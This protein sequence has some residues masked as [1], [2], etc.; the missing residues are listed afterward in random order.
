M[1]QFY[2]C[3]I[4]NIILFCEI[5]LQYY[6]NVLCIFIHVLLITKLSFCFHCSAG[7]WKTVLQNCMYQ[8]FLSVQQ[9][10]LVDM[11]SLFTLCYSMFCPFIYFYYKTFPL[12]KIC[13]MSQILGLVDGVMT[14]YVWWISNGLF[15]AAQLARS[16]L[17]YYPK[18]TVH[19]S[20]AFFKQFPYL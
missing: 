18:S 20:V 5:L 11:A 15:N 16:F 6:T 13:T 8:T 17:L 7:V 9:E 4:E 10:V 19:T 12:Y 14:K 1:H 3:I 2:R